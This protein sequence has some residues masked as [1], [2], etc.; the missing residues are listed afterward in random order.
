MA[1]FVAAICHIL[2]AF[3]LNFAL[4]NKTKAQQNT[5]ATSAIQFTVSSSQSVASLSSISPTKT[6]AINN[7]S[8]GETDL[9]LE[10]PD[11]VSCSDLGASCIQ[12]EFNDSCI[13]G[14]DVDVQC[15]AIS[16]IK[17]TVSTVLLLYTQT[18]PNERFRTFNYGTEVSI[19]YFA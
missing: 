18:F 4:Q 5:E 2:V 6:T 13:Y 15:K 1:D 7:S 19:R 17:C 10:C 3:L 11:G 14:N 12:C 8:S 9:Y 16:S